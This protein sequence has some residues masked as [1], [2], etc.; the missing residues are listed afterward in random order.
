MAIG[1]TVWEVFS[2][3][4]EEI[5]NLPEAEIKQ[6]CQQVYVQNRWFEETNVRF[7]L[8][9]TA[10]ML[11]H[12][13]LSH[14]MQ[15]YP[16]LPV[17][18]PQ[19]IGVVMAGN[20][21]LV[22][23]HDALCVLASGHHLMA[24]LS[25]DDQVLML[26]IFQKLFSL[27]PSLATKVSLVDKIN[28]ADAVIAT[29]SDNTAKHFEYYFANKPRIIRK[30]RVSV[31]ILSGE[32]SEDELHALGSDLFRYFGLGCRNVSKIFIPQE[33]DL[34][35]FFRQIETWRPI[36]DHHKFNN[37]YEYNRAIYLLKNIQHLDNGFVILTETTDLVSPIAVI[38]VER[39]SDVQALQ[40]YLQTQQ[41]KLQC[42]VA[43][44]TFWPGATPF[45]KAQSPHVWEYA[46]GIDTMKFL[47]SL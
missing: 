35:I 26:F 42:I 32:E 44:G 21:P 14:W 20:I 30:N 18:T 22:G 8:E 27:E 10:L 19:K 12:Q 1:S 2:R 29:G 5:T 15:Q 47:S 37:N 6:L 16:E 34:S 23:F 38:Y 39:Y 41:Q 9:Q 3:L 28:A 25:S 11:R 40:D 36:I 24:K 4:G 46:D 43:S 33:Y 17:S 45:G 31:A 13:D 7:A